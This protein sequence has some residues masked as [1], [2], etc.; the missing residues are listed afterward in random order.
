MSNLRLLLELRISSRWK[1]IWRY[2]RSVLYL[3][4]HP[5]VHTQH[6]PPLCGLHFCSQF[7]SAQFA[8]FCRHSHRETHV[9]KDGHRR[10]SE[11]SG[12]FDDI[13]HVW[14]LGY[15]QVG[16]G[17]EAE[18]QVRCC[19]SGIDDGTE[20]DRSVGM[21]ELER[22]EGSLHV[23]EGG[24]CNGII[25][26]WVHFCPL[27]HIQLYLLTIFLAICDPRCMD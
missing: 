24:N 19:V 3:P 7:P 20:T 2:C 10:W 18:K 17:A 4:I 22:Q 21:Q 27:F 6:L 13:V 11:L 23:I 25:R 12:G 9:R 14:D 5:S 1:L 8:C 15:I 26:Y 16:Q